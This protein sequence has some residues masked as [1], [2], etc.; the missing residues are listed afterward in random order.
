LPKQNQKYILRNYVVF[1]IKA[2]QQ[3]L[4]YYDKPAG[5]GQTSRFVHLL[6]LMIPEHVKTHNGSMDRYLAH[7]HP[8]FADRFG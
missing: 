2:I 6:S 1:D 4:G 7:I 8:I 3:W 5:V